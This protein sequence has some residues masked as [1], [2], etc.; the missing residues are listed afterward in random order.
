MKVKTKR[1]EKKE[2]KITNGKDTKIKPK[3]SKRYGV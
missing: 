1:N 3:T 2:K